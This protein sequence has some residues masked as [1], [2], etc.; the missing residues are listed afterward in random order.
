[1]IQSWELSIGTVLLYF[2]IFISE[3]V[4][5]CLRIAIYCLQIRGKEQEVPFTVLSL[6][7]RGAQL[8]PQ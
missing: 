1:M 6:L 3:I 7:Y 4:I 8:S 2:S 5:F